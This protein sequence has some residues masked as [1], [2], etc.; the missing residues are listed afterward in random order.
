MN[1]SFSLFDGSSAP[2]SIPMPDAQVRFMQ[3]FYRPPVSG[4]LMDRLIHDILWRQ[5]T[6]V[7]W[8]KPHLQPRLSAWYGDA[9]SSYAY[10]GVL[11]N[12]HPWTDTL[13][14]IKQDI[15]QAAGHRFNSVLLNLYRNE[16]DSVGWHSDAEPELGSMPV[17]ASLSLGETR[18][19]RFRHK[20]RKDLKPVS[21]ALTDGSLLLM[22]G[23]TQKFW[24]HAIVKEREVRKARINL[25]FRTILRRK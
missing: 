6:I 12:P 22:E 10:S 1:D 7:L 19:F 13:L 9:G 5:E 15:E 17:I 21:I 14:H 23:A 8:G 4:E 2:E 20:T 24:Q 11:L 18:T 3:A 16:Q 25:T